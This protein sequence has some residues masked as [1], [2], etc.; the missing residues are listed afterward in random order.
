MFFLPCVRRALLEKEK[1]RREQA[2]KDKERIERE[3]MEIMERLRQIE[4]QTMKAQKGTAAVPRGTRRLLR[5]RPGR[6]CVS[7]WLHCR[8]GGPDPPGC[9]PGAGEEES[10]GGS[11]KAGQGEAGDQGGHVGAGQTG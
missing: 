8:P 7:S 11:R 2:E 1:K 4:E 3:K 10:E 5:L 9:G 6:H